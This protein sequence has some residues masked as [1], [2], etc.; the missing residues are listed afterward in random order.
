MRKGGNRLRII[1][2]PAK[3]MNVDRDS[4]SCRSTAEFLPR[5]EELLRTLRTLSPQELQ[6]LW[7][8]ND[9]I[10]AQNLERLAHMDLHTCLTPAILSYEGIQYRYMAPAV[11][12]DRALDYLQ[13]HLRILSG[14]YGV[15]RP[16]DGVTP[17]RLEMQAKLAAGGAKD[18]Y[19]YW[20]AEIAEHVCRETDC[21]LN[22][23]SREYSLC[24]SRYLK[25]EVRFITC[26]FAERADG[27]LKEKGTLC[28]MAR[29]EM[30]RFLAECQAEAPEEAQAFDRLD[31]RYSP[32]DSDE[33]TYVFIREASAAARTTDV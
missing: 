15:L 27:R 17:Y 5:T 4:F 7:N 11:M 6:K 28:K 23:A 1:I 26:V 3:K 9:K 19:G 30:V 2:S 32:M 8:C 21:I 10:A 25:P 20:G 33:S 29:G 18:L 24:V 12:T 13:E 16:F 14:F 31:F 22:L